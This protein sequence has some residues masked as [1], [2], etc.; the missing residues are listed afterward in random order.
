LIAIRFAFREIWWPRAEL[1]HR[2]TDFQSAALPTELLGHLKRQREIVATDFGFG[3]SASASL[4]S[5]SRAVSL[6]RNLPR[7]RQIV[8]PLLYQLS[9]LAKLS[10]LPDRLCPT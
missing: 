2:H 10:I 6:R 4:N 1:N 7:N 3:R 8:S 5:P 9:Y